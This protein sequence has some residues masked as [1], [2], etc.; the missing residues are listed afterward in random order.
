MR[1]S[2]SGGVMVVGSGGIFIEMSRLDA[3]AA[4]FATGFVTSGIPR[5]VG[6]VTERRMRGWAIG[7]RD[8][9]VWLCLLPPGLGVK[10]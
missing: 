8:L 6:M 7:A 2:R 1:S 5:F 4:R 10:S 9:W 3:V